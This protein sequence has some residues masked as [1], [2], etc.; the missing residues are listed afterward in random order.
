MRPLPWR[1]I[2]EWLGFQLVWL[3]CA[4]GAAGGSGIPGTV[5]ALVFAA[6]VVGSSGVRRGDVVAV[7]ASGIAG[8]VLE[9]VLAATGVVR[10]AAPW[11]FETIAPAWMVAL[12]IAFGATLATFAKA[13][14]PRL[15]TAAGI[16]AI[17]GP[18]AY[19][20][21]HRLGALQL[22]EPL[23]RSLLIVALIWAV[24]LPGLI[25]LRARNG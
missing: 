13:L 5:A 9:S 12:W 23:P 20:A 22:A 3:A 6:V 1:T 2:A 10:F 18:L 16:G 25:A 24:V 15:V 11:P 7:A 19:L 21:G 17:A 4:L 14:G 8:L